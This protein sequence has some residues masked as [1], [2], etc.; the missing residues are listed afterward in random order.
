MGQAIG[1][2]NI[3][4]LHFHIINVFACVLS[5]EGL[6]MTRIVEWYASLDMAEFAGRLKLLREAR[7]L[8]QARLADL[9]SLTNDH[10]SRVPYFT[11]LSP[12]H[13][14][15]PFNAFCFNPFCAAYS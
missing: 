4:G 10:E 12:L 6:T 13:K 8:T 14:P 11:H 15:S 7:N 5:D 1:D 3:A 9:L 2:L